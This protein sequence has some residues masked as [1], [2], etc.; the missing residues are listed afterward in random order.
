LAEDKLMEFRNPIFTAYGAIDCEID[1][2]VYGWIPFTADPNDVEPV[3]AEVFNAAK[4][5]AAP[6]VAPPAPTPEEVLQAERTAMV[7]TPAQ[8]R[9]TL[10]RAGL[11]AQV[12]EI[13]DSDPEASIVWEYATQIVRNDPFIDALG[14]DFTPE[15]IDDLFRSAMAV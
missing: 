7:C 6:Y 3:G 12:Q 10:H 13:A 2:P 1:H 15:Q 11:L 5:S 4:D 14:G 9:L 8:M